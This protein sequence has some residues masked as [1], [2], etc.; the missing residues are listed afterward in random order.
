LILEALQQH[1]KRLRELELEEQDRRGYRTHP[2]RDA[3]N[4][5]DAVLSLRVPGQ[6]ATRSC[7]DSRF[8]TASE[9]RYV[10]A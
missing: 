9:Y 10:P 5:G 3:L 4:K 1:L 2:Q 8:H 7:F 6:A